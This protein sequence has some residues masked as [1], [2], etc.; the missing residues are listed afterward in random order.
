MHKYD[1]RNERATRDIVSRGMYQ[2]MREGRVNKVGGLY[3]TMAHL[4]PVMVRKEFK[5]MV[6]ALR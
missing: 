5:G 1:S 6:E 4:D 2:E 3:I